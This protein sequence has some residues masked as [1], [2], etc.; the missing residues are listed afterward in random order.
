MGRLSPPTAPIAEA[1]LYQPVKCFLEAR[2]YEVKGE[3]HGCDV[4][5]RRAGEPP[6]IVELKLRF[7][8][9]LV[10]QATD[11]LRVC[12]RVYVA[13]PRPASRARG[14]APDSGP[15][16]RLCR[17]LG[18]GLLVVG[19]ETVAVV[20][21]PVPY[22]P[23][24]SKKRGL[25]LVSEFERRAGDPN[26]GG[27]NRAPIVTAYRQDALRCARAIAES[28]PMRLADLRGATGVA[29]AAPILQRNVYG[30]F[31]RLSR[32]TY[33]LTDS[34]SAALTQFAGAFGDVDS[35]RAVA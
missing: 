7:T 33:A 8:L 17:R 9:G 19:R 25:R 2:G 14:I 3:I 16:R 32:G 34:G 20:E 1:A 22:R 28:G 12:E 21:E 29:S 4:V 6:I 27:R 24:L 13:V 15:I 10:L 23:R 5:A 35:E 11:R 18:L 26:I 31:A 30:W